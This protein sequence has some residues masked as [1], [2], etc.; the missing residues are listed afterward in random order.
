MAHAI[1]EKKKS[2]R[3]RLSALR[4]HDEPEWAWDHQSIGPV[5]P[6]E[7]REF[8]SAR[9]YANGS[10]DFKP[11][12]GIVSKKGGS[13]MNSLPNFS[14]ESRHLFP[15]RLDSKFGR[16]LNLP[17]F[18]KP[19]SDNGSL[20][21]SRSSLTISHDSPKTN[22]ALVNSGRKLESGV[23]V[24]SHVSSRNKLESQDRF[25]RID[26]GKHHSNFLS[27]HKVK[28]ISPKTDLSRSALKKATNSKSQVQI[29]KSHQQNPLAKKE[30]LD[31]NLQKA[32]TENFLEK[33]QSH[34]A[35]KN[36]K[37]KPPLSATDN[38][39]TA[40]ERLPSCKVLSKESS[41]EDDFNQTKVR[42]FT[43]AQRC[44]RNL[45]HQYSQS[46]LTSIP[47]ESKKV[48]VRPKGSDYYIG[49]LLEARDEK[50]SNDYFVKIR[51]SHFD[52]TLRQYQEYQKIIQGNLSAN[53]NRPRKLTDA[54]GSKHLRQ[55]LI[56]DLD[57]TLV[58]CAKHKMNVGAVQVEL[59]IPPF[60]VH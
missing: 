39:S 26:E 29:L 41:L 47:E 15:S 49:P 42:N 54:L 11:R 20:V 16:G 1:S 21:N 13:S 53:F 2:L 52:E 10:F 57:E 34:F 50:D 33:T 60:K 27:Q 36:P 55:Y 30:L 28:G 19:F 6:V 31:T 12:Y 40:N 8:N 24:A 48:K 25:C 43:P 32:N 17:T 22:W 46:M 35:N 44:S 5:C 56:L 14:L 38:L 18:E 7:H 3:Q 51:L 59:P 9:K 37:K 45:N 23:S 58:Y 4:L